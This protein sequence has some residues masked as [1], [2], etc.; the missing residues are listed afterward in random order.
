MLTKDRIS[1]LATAGRTLTR[2]TANDPDLGPFADLPGIWKSLPGRGWN[3][4]ALP[5]AASSTG[6]RLLLNQYDEELT[7]SLVDKAVPNRGVNGRPAVQTDQLLVALDYQQTIVQL[8]AAEFPATGQ[9]GSPGLPIHHEPGLFL[10][11]ANEVTNGRDIARIA[12]IPH[13][14][15][16]LA[17]G[18]A[19]SL[20]GAPSIPDISALPIGVDVDLTTPYMAPYA[21]FANAPFKGI[22][23]PTQTTQLLRSALAGVTVVK[24]QELLFDTTFETG[25][26]HNIPFVTREANAA[27]MRSHFWIETFLDSSGA[28]QL[29]LQYAQVVML[30]F[31][32]RR[33]GLPG[34]IR[35]PH[36][37]I[38]TLRKQ[39][40]TGS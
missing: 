34:L 5:S 24:T 7:F 9:Q 21:H 38:N 8:D 18:S 28:Q 32:G 27:S 19:S 15:A 17:L 3:L 16:V 33:D 37:S 31:F 22:F 6:Y 35:W 11:M 20:D 39:P 40:G 1:T 30:D 10:H 12:T 25:G 4:I 13:G 23:D 36:I 26:I 14:D 2:A 29:Q